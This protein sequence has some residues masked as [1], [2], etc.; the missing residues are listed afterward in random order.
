MVLVPT[1][2]IFKNIGHFQF[3]FIHACYRR[4]PLNLA[5]WISVFT[6]SVQ[7]VNLLYEW[8]TSSL[9]Y[10]ILTRKK[11]HTSH[12]KWTF[13]NSPLHCGHWQFPTQ[14]NMKN[15]FPLSEWLL[16]ILISQLHFLTCALTNCILRLRKQ[17]YASMKCLFL[18][19]NVFCCFLSVVNTVTQSSKGH[20]LPVLWAHPVSYTLIVIQ[21]CWQGLLSH[22]L[23]DL[24]LSS[25]ICQLKGVYCLSFQ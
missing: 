24:P 14:Y 9:L 16:L 6:Y 11:W 8:L 7:E 1:K 5:C 13:I 25:C 18:R 4:T 17:V 3:G 21:T 15:R 22:S 23:D 19:L 12:L 2:L 20:F 10:S